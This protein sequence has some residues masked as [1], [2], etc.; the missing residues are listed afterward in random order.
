MSELSS[1][2]ILPPRSANEPRYQERTTISHEEFREQA[3]NFLAE[4]ADPTINEVVP[5]LEEYPAKWQPM[6][7]QIYDLGI[8]PEL[9]F[10]RLHVWPK[11]LR[12]AS[13][14][15]DVIHNHPRHIAS[16]VLSGTYRD[17]IFDVAEK[18]DSEQES[19]GDVYSVYGKTINP[20]Q[21]E[22][23]STEGVRVEATV[24]ENRVVPAGTQH[25]IPPDIFHQTQVPLSESCVT[26]VFNSFRTKAEGPFV[27]LNKPPRSMPEL[28]E[29]I[30]PEEIAG[31]KE[32]FE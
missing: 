32:L 22:F 31:V 20:D 14:K 1:F 29:P 6:G 11:I 9:G 4:L 30:T 16:N 13:Q 5:N 17:L 24:A 3:G 12:R 25:F 28:R 27:L 23:L 21:T 2:G 8:Y 7:F 26:L 15:A 18:N 10:L 19:E